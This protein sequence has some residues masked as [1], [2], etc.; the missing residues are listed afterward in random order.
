MRKDIEA[1]KFKGWDDKRLPTL[2]S[3]K[4]QGYKSQAFWRF[5]GRVGLSENDKVM[6]RKEYFTLLDSFNRQ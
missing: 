6:D 4:K 1:G 3:L 5:A 2:A